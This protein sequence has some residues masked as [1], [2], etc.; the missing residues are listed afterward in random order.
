LPNTE[1]RKHKPRQSLHL[2]TPTDLTGIL[3]QGE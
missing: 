1:E 2:L 3:Y